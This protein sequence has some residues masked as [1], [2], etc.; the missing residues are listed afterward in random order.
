MRA[1]PLGLYPDVAEVLARCALQAALTHNTPDGIR[2][3]AGHTSL[4]THFTY[5]WLGPKSALPAFLSRH[6]PGDW[7]A[8]P[9]GARSAGGASSSPVSRPP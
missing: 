3:A 2:A 7:S 8:A 6:L 5:Y 4:M 1:A 9:G